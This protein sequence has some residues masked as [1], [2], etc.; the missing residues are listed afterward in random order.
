MVIKT[1]ITYD[2][3]IADKAQTPLARKLQELIC[4][5]KIANQLK[6]Y[7][8]V[9]IQ[10][11][12]QYK[13]GTAYP[14]TENLIKIADFFGISVDYLLGLTG[15]P[16]RDTSIQ[17][18]HDVTGLSADAIVK[19]HDLYEKNPETSFSEIISLMIEDDNAEF[20]LAVISSLLSCIDTEA[21]KDIVHLS[22]D[23]KDE[24][25]YKET[26]LKML[27]QIKLLDM[28]SSI[29]D[30]QRHSAESKED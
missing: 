7:L 24:A 5:A 20:F 17:A 6:E 1:N 28:L 15:V 30:K 22:I 2:T 19:L 25:L 23:G 9:S 8:G 26:H 12:N 21:G 13:M 16:N 10:A 18:V 4:N 11:I 14:K 3:S 29:A 27:L